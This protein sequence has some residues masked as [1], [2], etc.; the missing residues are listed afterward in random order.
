MV[1][2]PFAS[3]VKIGTGLMEYRALAHDLSPESLFGLASRRNPGRA[4]LFV[5]RILGKHIPVRPGVMRESHVRL[6]GKIRDLSPPGPVCFMGMAETALGLARGVFEEYAL[7]EPPAGL[8]FTQTTRYNLGSAEA[9][10]VD[11]SHCHAREH[12]VYMPAEGA[13]GDVFLGARTLAVVDDELSTGNTLL[14]LVRAYRRLNPGL[15]RVA[16]ASLTDWLPEGR[17][18]GMAGA[19]GLPVSFV[20]LLKGVFSFTPGPAAAE[21]AGPAAV[22]NWEDKSPILS[23][24]QGRLGLLPGCGGAAAAEAAGALGLDPGRPVRVIGTGEFLYEPYRLALALEDAGHDVMF[25]ATTRTPALV[26]GALAG[27]LV[28]PDNYWDGIDNFLY[29]PPEDPM[30]QNVLVYETRPLPPDHVLPDLLG[31]RTV[32]L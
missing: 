2:P 23:Q 27:R 15:E 22:G 6:A 26:G 3:S 8:A 12:V 5:S 32:F 4:F 20:S 30:S 19:L 21:T 31:A 17:A 28:F 1:P 9:F 16:V 24:S 11:E 29:N 14:N 25:Q 10:R 18:E 13:V 7:M